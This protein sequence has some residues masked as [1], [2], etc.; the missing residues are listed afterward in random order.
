[1]TGCTLDDLLEDLLKACVTAGA[2]SMRTPPARWTG[3]WA[4]LLQQVPHD[5]LARGLKMT[6]T[7]T[8]I[9]ESIERS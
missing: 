5:L 6:G 8:D 7:L 3:D 2:S 4:S 1:M 9:A